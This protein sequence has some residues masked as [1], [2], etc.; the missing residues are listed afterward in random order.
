MD[1]SKLFESD[2]IRTVWNEIDQKWYFVVPDVI[3]VLTDSP[4]PRDYVK[5]IRRRDKELAKGWGQIVTQLTV[6]TAGGKQNINCANVEGLLR[7]ILAIPSPKAEPFKLW[8]AKVGSERLNN[9]GKIE[10]D[11]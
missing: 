3:Q 11:Y 1:N 5:K 8:L 10:L 4:D 7:I 2:Q 9:L 6:Q